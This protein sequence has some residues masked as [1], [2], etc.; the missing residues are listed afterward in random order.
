VEG[1]PHFAT[2]KRQQTAPSHHYVS[3]HLISMGPLTPSRFIPRH[4]IL[5]NRK[6]W[7]N[8][9]SLEGEHLAVCS[10]RYSD[11]VTSSESSSTKR[12]SDVERSHHRAEF[13]NTST[14][15][16]QQRKPC[17]FLLPK[18]SRLERP[19]AVTAG[20]PKPPIIRKHPRVVLESCR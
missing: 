12:P 7:L 16:S 8:N 15:F 18:Y 17:F 14:P 9:L 10:S 5:A 1:I 20:R 11:P 13:S 4:F 2:P 19:I 3:F 6:A